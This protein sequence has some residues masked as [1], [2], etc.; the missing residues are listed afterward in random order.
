MQAQRSDLLAR[1]P[2][3]PE[4]EHANEQ[5][6]E[7]R[8]HQRHRRVDVRVVEERERHRQRQQHEQVEVQQPQRAAEVEERQ[9]EQHAQRQPYVQ[10]VHV[11]AERP[12]VAACHRPRHLEAGPLFEHP[13]G[14][15]V[16]DDLPDLL[17]AVAREVAHLP[18]KR[19]LQVGA[20][21]GAGIFPAHGAHL[22]QRIC[23]LKDAVRRQHA[24][25]RRSV[26]RHHRHRR[27]RARGLA[28]RRGSSA[29]R[30]AQ[31]RRQG[32]V[33]GARHG[34]RRGRRRGRGRQRT[35]C[36]AHDQRRQAAHEAPHAAADSAAAEV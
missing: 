18:A 14:G 36:C 8:V 9:H 32:L 15:V 30:M 35:A 23:D 5:I 19:A 21:V 17:L 13:A 31:G 24:T 6:D 27:F 25:G 3:A 2:A 33:Q 12:A 10:R 1:P 28:G 29:A 11:P 34:V 16:D 22:R 26:G 7:R 4:H 20:A